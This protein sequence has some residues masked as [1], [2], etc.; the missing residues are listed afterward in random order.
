MRSILRE[1]MEE[2]LRATVG[3]AG[4]R[5]RGTKSQRTIFEG[6][7][8]GRTVLTRPCRSLSTVKRI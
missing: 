2:I 4:L 8:N 6:E 3:H 5:L 7:G 1:E